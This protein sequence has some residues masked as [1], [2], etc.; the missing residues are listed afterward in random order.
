MGTPWTHDSQNKA[1]CLWFRLQWRCESGWEYPKKGGH[2]NLCFQNQ[3]HRSVKEGTASTKDAREYN[4]IYK[5]AVRSGNAAE[6]TRAKPAKQLQ[7]SLVS[8]L[9]T[10]AKIPKDPKTERFVSTVNRC[11]CRKVIRKDTGRVQNER[12]LREKMLLATPSDEWY[13]PG[14]V[15]RVCNAASKYTEI[16]LKD[17]I[18]AAHD[19]LQGLIWTFLRFRE[20][21]I[22][23]TAD[24]ESMFLQVQVPEQ[25]RGCLR[26]LWRPRTNE[27]VQ[28]YEYQSQGFR[29]KS[30]PTCAD[31]ALKR[32]GLD[33]EKEYPIASNAIQ[34]NF[35]KGDF[36]KSKETPEQVIEFASQLR[37]ILLPYGFELMEWISNHDAVTEAVSEYLKSIS[38]TK[39]S[40]W[41]PIRR[42]PQCKNYNGLLLMI[43]F[44]YAEVPAKQLKHL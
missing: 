10:G 30:S 38:N 22:V 4:E 16:C 13:L 8:A 27:P 19:V 12:H 18:L 11:R 28:I 6:C 29:A 42:D 26:I 33:S 21:P 5:R 17:K 23:L 25:D 2:R 39:K 32:M 41:N 43:V 34:N 14:K 40:K 44:K 31:Y 9:F 37:H 3:R 24:I 20:E 7:L 1:R 15:R 35:Y 36:I